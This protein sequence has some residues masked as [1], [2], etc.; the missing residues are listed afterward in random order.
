MRR[1]IPIYL[2]VWKKAS[3]FSY[4]DITENKHLRQPE[5][6]RVFSFSIGVGTARQVRFLI[7]NPRR[8]HFVLTPLLLIGTSWF[9]YARANPAN[10]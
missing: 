7:R 8:G 10:G 1:K 9:G 6:L 2:Q 5:R 3:T 4:C